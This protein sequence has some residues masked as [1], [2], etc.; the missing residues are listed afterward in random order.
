MAVFDAICG[1]AVGQRQQVVLVGFKLPEEVT[2][3][4]AAPAVG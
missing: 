3:P 4:A 2:N 1:Q